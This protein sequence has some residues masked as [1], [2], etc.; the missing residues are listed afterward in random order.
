M[1]RPMNRLNNALLLLASFSI[2]APLSVGY[3]GVFKCKN[4]EGQAVFQDRPCRNPGNTDPHTS[5]S[6]SKKEHDNRHF[7]WKASSESG[8]VHLFGSIHFGS[9]EM[10]PLPKVVTEAYAGSDAL[11]VEVN[12][13]QI[14]TEEMLKSLEQTGTYP[15]GETVQQHLS[16]ETWEKFTRTVKNQKLNLQTLQNKKPWLISL[17]LATLAIQKSGFSPKFGIDQYFITGAEGKKPI[18]ELETAQQQMDLLSTFSLVEQNKLLDET[19][20]QLEQGPVYFRSIL[21]AW[22]IGDSAKIKELTQSEID[23]DPDARKLYH[24]LF[25]ARNHAMSKKIDKIAESGKNYFVVVGAGHLVGEEGIVELLRGKGYR[26][27]QL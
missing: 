21:N 17:S 18:L 7:L 1:N 12:T 4:P 25:T 23:T 8:T 15:Q 19:L 5:A 3:S 10:Y 9:T 14:D 20:S 22:Q 24:A 26:L 6:V 27:T 13:N 11:I 16:P 2:L